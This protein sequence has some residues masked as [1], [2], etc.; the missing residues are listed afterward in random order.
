MARESE[1][2]DNITFITRWVQYTTGPTA[3]M[4]SLS[5]MTVEDLNHLKEAAE[6]A[7]KLAE[8]TE[9]KKVA[10]GGLRK[11]NVLVD[12][13]T[14]R[15]DYGMTPSIFVTCTR[16]E[17]RVEVYGQTEASIKRGCMKLHEQCDEQNFYVYEL[18]NAS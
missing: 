1:K 12:H 5:Y 6:K 9:E 15:G 17:K 16:C 4:F 18:K 11:V 13:T 14:L 7:L 10:E 2:R 3:R 8:S